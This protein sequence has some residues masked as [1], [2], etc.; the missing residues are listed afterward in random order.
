MD[1]LSH[2]R[3]LEEL[4]QGG[5]GVVYKAVD[6][7][8]N[9]AV[10]LKVLPPDKIANSERK[11]RFIQEARAASALNHPNIITIY[12][13]AAEGA[14]DFMAMEF[15]AGQT[16]ERLIPPRGMRLPEA[17]KIAVQVA[18]GLAKAHAAGIVHRDLKPSNIMVSSDGLV[19][20]LDFGLAKLTETVALSQSDATVTQHLSTSPRT[21]EGV[22]AGTI[23]YMSP[24]QAEGKPVDTRS[25]VFSFGSVLYEMVTGHRAFTGETSASTLGAVIHKEPIVPENLPREVDRLLRRCLRKEPERRFQTMAD[26]AVALQEVADELQSSESHDRIRAAQPAPARRSWRLVGTAAVVALVFGGAGGWWIAGRNAPRPMPRWGIRQLTTDE[27]WTGSG[28][29]S[30]DGRMVAYISDRAGKGTRDLWVQQVAGG[31]PIPLTSGPSSVYAPSFSPDGSRIIY[32]STENPGGIYTIPVLGGESRRIADAQSGGYAQFSPDGRWI[33]IHSE[34]AYRTFFEILPAAGGEARRIDPNLFGGSYFVW[35]PDSSGILLSA[36]E[37][38]LRDK[39]D[40]WFL[41]LDGQKTRLPVP[42]QLSAFRGYGLVA[43]QNAGLYLMGWQSG[44]VDL[45]RL[46]LSPGSMRPGI[47]EPLT[48]GWAERNVT[49]LGA[50]GRGFLFT[51]VGLSRRGLWSL[52]MD[53]ERGVARGAARRVIADQGRDGSPALSA[54]GLLAFIRYD[55]MGS[56]LWSRDILTEKTVQV[57][58]TGGSADYPVPSRDGARIAFREF[59]KGSPVHVVSANGGAARRVCASCGRVTDWSPDGRKLWAH[60]LGGKSG[61]AGT[62]DVLTGAQKVRLESQSRIYKP[63]VSPDGRWVAFVVVLEAGQQGFIAPYREDSAIPESEWIPV[64]QG[65]N[66]TSMEWSPGGKMLYYYPNTSERTLWAI[67]LDPVTGRSVGDPK[68]VYAPQAGLK[69]IGDSGQVGLAVSKDRIYFTQTE[70]IH[71]NVWLAEISQP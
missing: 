49:S 54:A 39:R 16:L 7:R 3:I 12:D 27:G 8:L 67:A 30:P 4:G 48:T 37:T 62:I 38:V 2:Y 26:L 17:L 40:L 41:T 60:D 44:A 47:L 50:G 31:R 59:G 33:A 19:K 24:E 61:K 32:T 68:L 28:A 55:R 58:E 1:N 66:I 21:A 43:W 64:R 71:G 9:R 25:D 18:H 35:A 42:A 10:A 57:T 70:S 23:A 29:L 45:W 63:R 53:V 13:I 65:L 46:E 20:V 5:M 22:V 11:A 36:G 52:E 15:V 6:T 56:S 69:L 34:Y 14:I 51:G